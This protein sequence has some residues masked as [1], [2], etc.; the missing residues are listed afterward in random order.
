MHAAATGTM[1][2]GHLRSTVYRSVDVVLQGN[3]VYVM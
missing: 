1:P 2:K 3:A